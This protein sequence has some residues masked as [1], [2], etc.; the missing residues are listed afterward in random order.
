MN[1][2]PGRAHCVIDFHAHLML[3]EIYAIT[4][5]HS[6]F[7]KSNTDPTMSEEARQGVREREAVLV[8]RMSDVTERIVHTDAMGVD[9]QV[10]SSSLVQQSTYWAEPKESLR[11]ER[12]L[13]DRMAA[14]VAAKLPASV[15]VVELE[16]GVGHPPVRSPVHLRLHRQQLLSRLARR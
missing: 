12:T 2:E 9:M 1:E 5:P 10:L 3:P 13:N 15:E 11:M 8:S 4:G 14:V 6:M 16:A 7:V